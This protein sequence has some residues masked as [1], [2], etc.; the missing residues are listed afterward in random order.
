MTGPGSVRYLNSSST[1]LLSSSRR[2]PLNVPILSEYYTSN[3]FKPSRRPERQEYLANSPKRNYCDMRARAQKRD[4]SGDARHLNRLLVY[5]GELAQSSP[6]KARHGAQIELYVGASAS[7]IKSL[8]V[9]A[10]TRE[11]GAPGCSR[12]SAWDPPPLL[13][14]EHWGMER[15]RVYG[16]SASGNQEKVTRKIAIGRL[17]ARGSTRARWTQGSA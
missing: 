12:A 6:R 16:E 2:S 17:Y 1:R 3:G 8:A 4:A 13:S 14:H 15:L 9:K 10:G 11:S 5:T 7:A